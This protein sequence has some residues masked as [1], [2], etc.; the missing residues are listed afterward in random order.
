MVDGTSSKLSTLAKGSKEE[1]LIHLQH[2]KF[3]KLSA[4]VI[5]NEFSKIPGSNVYV[6]QHKE[7]MAASNIEFT[8]ICTNIRRA[9]VESYVA[10]LHLFLFVFGCNYHT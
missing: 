1:I 2:I 9:C 7:F 3:S 4:S 6:Y 8:N 10:R 5:Q